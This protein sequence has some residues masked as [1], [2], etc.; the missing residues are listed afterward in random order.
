M[1]TYRIVL[2]VLAIVL[3]SVTA[4]A[5][6][7]GPRNFRAHLTGEGAGTDSQGQGQ[8]IFRFS[9]DGETLH[10][11]LIVANIEN[12][13][14]AHIHVSADPGGSGPPALWLYPSAPPPQLIPGRSDGVL[15]Q[16]QATA[17]DLVGPLT[18]ATLDDLRMA[19]QEGRTY[20][21]V[22]TQQYPAGEIRGQIH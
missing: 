1:R 19:I 16:G 3:A 12:V 14:M 2:I 5:A 20:V 7:S 8:A 6:G 22:H 18:G 21:N 13:T 4:V 15:A 17:A 10:Y 9:K 11:K